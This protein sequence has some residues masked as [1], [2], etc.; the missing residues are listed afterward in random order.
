MRLLL[1]AVLTTLFSY[2]FFSGGGVIDHMLKTD[3]T[4]FCFLFASPLLMLSSFVL[5]QYLTVQKGRNKDYQA[6][7]L[8]QASGKFRVF[9]YLYSGCILANFGYKVFLLVGFSLTVCII[10]ACIIVLLALIAIHTH[11]CKQERGLLCVYK[12][13]NQHF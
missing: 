1:I 9:G 4:W 12:H 13:K 7:Y 11:N 8:Y 6:G 10:L 3:P 2:L 5:D